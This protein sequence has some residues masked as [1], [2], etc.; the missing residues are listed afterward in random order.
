MIVDPVQPMNPGMEP[1]YGPPM[2]QQIDPNNATG[3]SDASH[4]LL[5]YNPAGPAVKK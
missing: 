5:G 2:G 1:I 3:I 4:P